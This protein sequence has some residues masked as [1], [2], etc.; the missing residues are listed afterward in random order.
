M[1]QIT[2]R[3]TSA[4]PL[5]MHN[6]QLVDPL[7]TWTREIK[8]ISGKRKKVEADHAELA[9]VEYL[10]SLYMTKVGSKMRP[11]IP[12]TMVEAC[13]INAARTQKRGRQV[14]A[15][16]VVPDDAVLIYDGPT[17]ADA[18]AAD[19]LFTLRAPAK[20]GTARIMRTRPMFKN[21]KADI[22]V[23]YHSSDLDADILVDLMRIAGEIIGMGDWRPKF[24]RFTVERL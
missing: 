17:N 1:E 15:G 16:V 4:A 7:N 24:G 23:S 3:L 14:Q 20:V 13:L 6:A 22:C 2:F 19:P 11:C 18:L 5:L 9:R 12:S 21:W 10:G 8:R